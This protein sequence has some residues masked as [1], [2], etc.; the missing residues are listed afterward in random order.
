MTRTAWF[1]D[2]EDA[3]LTPMKGHP[4]IDERREEHAWREAASAI[5]N[6]YFNSYMS[7]GLSDEQIE[8]ILLTDLNRVNNRVGQEATEKSRRAKTSVRKIVK[9]ARRLFEK[10]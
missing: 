3:F 7:A 2:L 10:A 4:F 1:D 8:G 5:M 9:A 6:S